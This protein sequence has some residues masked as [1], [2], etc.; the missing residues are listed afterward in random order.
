M[1]AQRR[2]G[3]DDADLAAADARVI[4]L[5][6]ELAQA[7]AD[8]AVAAEL[9]RERLTA[10]KRYAY[11]VAEVAAICGVTRPTVEHWLGLLRD[12]LPYYVVGGRSDK[13]VLASEL[14][15]FFRRWRRNPR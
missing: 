15:E 12:P 10:S 6:A 7:V 3:F 9:A 11:T 13:R 4:A 2:P 14:D 1:V 5:T 8:R